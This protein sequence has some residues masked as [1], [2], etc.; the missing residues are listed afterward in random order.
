MKTTPFWTEECPRP[1]DLPVSDLPER[2]DVAVIG[3]GYTGLNAAIAL[4]KA[5][6]SVAV[7]EQQTIGWGASSRNGGM[8]TTG[9]KEEMPNVFKRYGDE[10]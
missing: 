6:A 7:L 10:M 8:A 9:L 5:G 4:R 3:S 1:A 2:V